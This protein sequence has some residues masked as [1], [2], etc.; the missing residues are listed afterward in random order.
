VLAAYGHIEDI[1][2]DPR[3]WKL[4]VRGAD[5]LAGALAAHRADAALYKKLATLRSDAPL[6]EK[7]ADLEW[8]GARP[9][10]RDFCARQG[11]G[12]LPERVRR[13]SPNP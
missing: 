6:A 7:L 12:E 9:A 1:P 13:W 5:R 8:K 10:F 11:F 3:A 4:S 2:D